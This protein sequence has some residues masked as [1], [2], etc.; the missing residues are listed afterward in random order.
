VWVDLLSLDGRL[1]QGGYGSGNTAE[2]AMLR[3]RQRYEQEQE[4]GRP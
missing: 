2:D 3:A 4:G 1:I